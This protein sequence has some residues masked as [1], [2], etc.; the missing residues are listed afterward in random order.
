MN[1]SRTLS[2]VFNFFAVLLLC[3]VLLPTCGGAG[4]MAV[5]FLSLLSFVRRK[6]PP[7]LRLLLS[8]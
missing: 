5:L 7:Y 3:S 4:I 1:L 6:V 2:T 8:E